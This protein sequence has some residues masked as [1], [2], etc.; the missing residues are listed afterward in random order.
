MQP[1]LFHLHV[2]KCGGTSLNALLDLQAHAERARPAGA[3]SRQLR[4]RGVQRVDI[5]CLQD[6]LLRP[7]IVEAVQE[8]IDWFDILHG[9]FDLSPWLSGED[10]V[11]TVLR[12]PARR[13]L[14]Q[15]H[16]YRRLAPHDYAHKAE[17]WQAVHEA[18]RG[19]GG[20]APFQ[21]RCAALSPFRSMFEDHQCRALTQHEV[22]Q[23]E[24]DAMPPAARAEAA[25]RTLQSRCTR[26]GVLEEVDGLLGALARDQGWCPPDPLAVSNRATPEGEDD[27][28]GLAKAEAITQGDRILYDRAVAALRDRP[29]SAY[30]IAEFE[31]EFAA[32]RLAGLSPARI[33]AEH[34]FDMNMPLPSRGLHGRD[35]AGTR[36]CCRW[37]GARAEALVYLP[38]PGPG[39]RLTL[40]LYNKG[41]VDPALRAALT[42]SVDGVPVRTSPEPR[43]EVAEA[44][45]FQATSRRGWMR[46][47]LHCARAMT[48]AEAGHA[49]SDGRRKVFNL[50]RCS[51]EIG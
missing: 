2:S 6:P 30:T 39:A 44:L 13:A 12:E 31:A 22:P 41:W 14:S 26:F 33:G 40:R 37:V 24:F 1:K 32:A 43:R 42:V 34:V 5:A 9:H 8:S 19:D 21:A 7:Q 10:T 16:D 35:A 36:D 50:W 51:Y 49:G 23:A 46:I 17:D 29:G 45:R 4:Q 47:G 25:W 20:F 11:F 38:V 15:F 28:A 18:A 48:D 3:F 27:P